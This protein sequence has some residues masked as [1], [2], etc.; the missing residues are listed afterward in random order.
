[1]ENAPYKERR[2]VRRRVLKSAQITFNGLASAIDCTIRDISDGG[3]YLKVES[4]VGIPDTF[5]LAI[6]GVP[7]RP[8]HLV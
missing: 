1:M 8:C 2:T 3:A 6:G 7:L 5:I 4:P